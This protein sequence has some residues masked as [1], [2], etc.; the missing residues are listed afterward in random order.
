[1]PLS[2][3]VNDIGGGD[4]DRKRI[5]AVQSG[6]PLSGY[7]P[8]DAIDTPIERNAFSA[9]GTLVGS[10]GLVVMNADRCIVE[11]T[12]MLTRFCQDESC[13]RCTTCRIGTMRLVDMS[14]R[15]ATGS[16]RIS[17]YKLIAAMEE[18][19]QDSNCVHG[20]FSATALASPLPATSKRSGMLTFGMAT[21]RAGNARGSSSMRSI[22][23]G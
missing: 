4:P 17:D 1:M 18:Y 13:G 21:V 20:Q 5:K 22:Q 7:V 11:M 2:L 10:G 6:G 12:R 8:G 3:V 19:L 14:D 16:G 9:L 23:T 15:A